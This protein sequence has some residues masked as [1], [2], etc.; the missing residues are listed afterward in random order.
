MAAGRGLSPAVASRARALRAASGLSEETLARRAGVSAAF[1]RRVERGSLASPSLRGLSALADAL[2][3]D[4]GDLVSTRPS[5]RRTGWHFVF[6]S[7]EHGRDAERR[8][9]AMARFPNPTAAALLA[10]GF[11]AVF[12]PAPNLS[13]RQAATMAGRPH[14]VPGSGSVQW[15]EEWMVEDIERTAAAR[16][17]SAGEP[18]R[19]LEN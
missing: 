19:D 18:R 13:D 8:M 3:T 6:V 12:V 1:V 2:G 14:L 4:L 10:G 16:S 5:A 17:A 7:H 11:V 15:F 9:R